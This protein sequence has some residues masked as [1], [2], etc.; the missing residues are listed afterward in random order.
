MIFRAKIGAEFGKKSD[1]TYNS[2]DEI[3]SQFGRFYKRSERIQKC[4]AFKPLIDNKKLEIKE[5]KH[6]ITAD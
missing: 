6:I 2:D 4:L 3:Q 5:M 1:P